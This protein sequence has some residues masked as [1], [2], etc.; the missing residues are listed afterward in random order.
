MDPQ[1]LLAR[2]H[3]RINA[4]EEDAFYMVEPQLPRSAPIRMQAAPYAIQ[5]IQQFSYTKGKTVIGFGESKTPEPFV[6]A[7]SV[8]IHTD[9]FKNLPLTTPHL[10]A[11]P[12]RRGTSS[13][14][15][16]RALVGPDSHD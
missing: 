3:R 4:L 10:P 13:A 6:K 15:Q 14:R 7:C 8:F 5:S 2:A 11:P 12:A 9:D 16:L 1:R